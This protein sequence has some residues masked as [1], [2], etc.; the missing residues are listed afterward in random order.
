MCTP[1]LGRRTRARY[2][3][4][5]TTE[6]GVCLDAIPGTAAVDTAIGDLAA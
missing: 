2:L 3:S 1:V 5:S 6:L 4:Q